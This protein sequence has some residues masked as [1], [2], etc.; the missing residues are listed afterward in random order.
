M[1]MIAIK[2]SQQDSI[3]LRHTSSRVRYAG[4]M[5]TSMA[6]IFAEAHCREAYALC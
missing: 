1:I 3:D 2:I 4:F 5:V 6:P